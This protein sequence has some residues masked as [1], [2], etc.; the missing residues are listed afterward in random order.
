MKKEKKR[1]REEAEPWSNTNIFFRN[2]GKQR[3]APNNGRG[4]N[5]FEKKNP[6]NHTYL[7]K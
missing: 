3:Q 1:K 6:F 4:L 7:S 2:P 5:T